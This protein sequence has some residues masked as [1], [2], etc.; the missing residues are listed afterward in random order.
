[1]TTLFKAKG[2]ETDFTWEVWAGLAYHDGP[3]VSMCFIIYWDHLAW[4]IILDHPPCEGGM[5]PFLNQENI[6]VPVPWGIPFNHSTPQK[7]QHFHPE[8]DVGTVTSYPNQHLYRDVTSRWSPKTPKYSKDIG[9]VSS[10]LKRARPSQAPHQSWHSPEPSSPQFPVEN[11]SPV[12]VM[13]MW[14]EPLTP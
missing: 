11:S 2:V 14:F 9:A 12:Q 1:M 8:V 4:L 3:C 7:F 5:A 13:G 10:L 6:F